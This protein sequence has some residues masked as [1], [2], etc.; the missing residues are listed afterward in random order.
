MVGAFEVFAKMCEDDNP[1]LQSAPLSNIVNMQ[2]CRGGAQ[3]TFGVPRE[4]MD[5][6]ATGELIGSFVVADKA[7]FEATKAK[8]GDPGRAGSMPVKMPDFRVSRR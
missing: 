4:I 2:I 5:K 8:D 6:I 1:A 7:A 3:I